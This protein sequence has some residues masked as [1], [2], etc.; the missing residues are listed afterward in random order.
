M[1]QI[2]IFVVFFLFCWLA[3]N[4]LMIT[5]KRLTI[6][7]VVQ[8]ERLT[9]PKYAFGE[10]LTW[11]RGLATAKDVTLGGFTHNLPICLSVGA[12]VNGIVIR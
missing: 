5:G 8:E 1:V 4:Q 2:A 6:P 11:K 9:V 12:V 3:I 10:K 7:F